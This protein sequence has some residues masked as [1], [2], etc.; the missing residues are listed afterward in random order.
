MNAIGIVFLIIGIIILLFIIIKL[1]IWLFTGFAIVKEKEVM[2]IERFGKYYKT[3]TAGLSFTWPFIDEFKSYKV[4]YFKSTQTGGGDRIKLIEENDTKISTQNE[5]MD[6]P[7]QSVITRDNARVQLDAILGYKITNAKI[8]V[9]SC[10][11]LPYLLSKLMQAQLRNTAGLLD[12][13]QIIEDNS[14]LDSIMGDVDSIAREWGVTVNLLKI[15]SVD[16]GKLSDALQEKMKAEFNN[17]KIITD[18]KSKRQQAIINAEAQRDKMIKEAEG[19]SQNIISNAKGEAKAI[20]NRAEGEAKS[21]K[22][23]ARAVKTSGQNPAKYLLTLKYIN[24]LSY[25]IS[26]PNTDVHIMPAKNLLLGTS[27]ELGMN[28]LMP[29]A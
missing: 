29:K 24:L 3:C 26:L 2:I 14:R 10:Q 8:M 4:R 9:Y 27:A 7:K 22:E 20:L 6:F 18:A 11:N 17:N 23:I 1:I 16:A 5:V 28:V 12:V 25:L 15:Q 19:K 13:D 21:V